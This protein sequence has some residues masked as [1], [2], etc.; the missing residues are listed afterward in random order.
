MGKVTF[1]TAVFVLLLGLFMGYLFKNK[2]SIPPPYS[3]AY[4]SSIYEQWDKQRTVSLKNGRPMADIIAEKDTVV[5][6]FWATWCPD[7]RVV[8]DEV[9]ALV[10]EGVPIIGVPLERDQEYFIY[11]LEKHSIP[12]DNLVYKNG[13]GYGFLGTANGIRIPSIPS[14]WV[15]KKGAMEKVFSGTKKGINELSEYLK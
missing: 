6:Y 10:A 12:W 14:W 2:S 5:L 11:Y 13:S 8:R 4:A 15:L 9:K 1:Y 3:T 7:C